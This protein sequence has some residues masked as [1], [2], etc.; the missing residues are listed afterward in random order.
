[1]NIVQNIVISILILASGAAGLIVFGKKPDVPVQEAAAGNQAVAVVTAPVSGWNQPFDIDLDGEAVTYR[2]VTVGAEVAGRIVTKSMAARGGTYVQKGDLL[3]EID[4]TNYRLGVDRL[5]AQLAQ[6]DEELKGIAVNLDNTQALLDLA[7]EDVKLQKNQ[8]VRMQKLQTRGTANETEVET[9]MKQELMARNALQTLQNQ[10]NTLAQQKSTT[11]ASRVLV[12]AE[13]KRAQED[14]ARCQV[15]SPLEG[16]IVD[17]A[18]EEGDYIKEGELLVHISDGSRMEIKTKLRSEELAWIWQQ[19]S[20]NDRRPSPD[21]AVLPVSMDPLNLPRIPCEV[22]YEFEGI[23]TIWDGYIARIEGTGIDRET[24]TFPCR[25][26]VEEPQKTRFNDSAGGRATVSPPTLLSG[27]FVSVRIPV[28]SPL[29]L[30]SLPVE[31]V[32]PGGQIWAVRDGKLDILEVTLA[33]VDGNTALVR[34]DGSG[35]SAGDRVIVSPLASV[36]EAMPVSDSTLENATVQKA[37]TAEEQ[38]TDTTEATE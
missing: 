25:V 10:K 2:V 26:L 6:I 14:L 16:R 36:K 15:V 28:E 20:V 32:R 23:E 17:D 29:A 30:L 9:A 34:R 4:D 21:G 24:R 19:Q 22:A 37:G 33:H 12:E 11:Q 13:L 1:M 31:A 7:N 38:A 3:F 5:K 18:V 8:L 35:L 27:M